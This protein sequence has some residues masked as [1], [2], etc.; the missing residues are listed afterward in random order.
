MLEVIIFSA[1]AGLALSAGAAFGV[2]RRLPV[3]VEGVLLAFAS[4]ALMSAVAF[5]LV[6]RPIEQVGVPAVGLALFAGAG[7]F[8]VAD[9]LLERAGEAGSVVI[10]VGF[11]MD[12]APETLALGAQPEVA[13]FAAI[14]ASNFP[15]ALVG[16]AEMREEG[17]RRRTVL[18]IWVV[19]S[20]FIALAGPVG[21]G[22]AE[23]A[24]NQ[25]SYYLSAFAGGAVLATLFTS[26]VP[27]A[28]ADSGPL[29]ALATV[30]GFLLSTS[31]AH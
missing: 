14:L 7:V 18:G 20:L 23:V 25:P 9:E 6:A 30:A 13:L 3:P 28:Y 8:L 1:L 17:H 24:G 31:L 12:G 5:E 11:V 2:Y 4:G 27:K 22:L 10:L 16:A 15:E 29:A 19:A 21:F 26:L